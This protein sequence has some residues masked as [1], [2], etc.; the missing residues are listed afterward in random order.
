[1]IVNA[2]LALRD[3][4][5]SA[6]VT[7]L[8]WDTESQ[9]D[10]TG[11][12]TNR[13]AKI[14]A[15][16]QDRDAVQRLF[17]VDNVAGRDW[18]LW[19][20]YFDAPG[21]VL[22]I[23]QDELDQLALEYPSQF[24]IVGAWKWDGAMV[25]CSLVETE[26]ANPAYVGEP[27]MMSNPAYQPDPE[28]PDYDPRLNIRNPAWVPEFITERSQSGTPTYPLHSRALELMPDVD[29]V[30][31]RPTEMSDVNLLLGQSPRVFS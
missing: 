18:T 21:N 5:Q 27:P 24:V 31:T 26:V 28:L 1:M 4:A 9:G 20:C 14:F 11:P 23:V 7:R 8:E 17:R 29:D 15:T 12:V 22:Q 30:G 19:N 3:D 6:L 25:G 2:W 10:Y 16:L 13:T